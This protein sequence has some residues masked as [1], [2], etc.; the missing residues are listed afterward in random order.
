MLQPNQRAPFCLYYN[1]ILCC[2]Q[3]SERHLFIWKHHIV[4]QRIQPA[5]FCLCDNNILCCSQS[6]GRPEGRC[7]RA[8]PASDR[9]S[10]RSAAGNHQS[11]LWPQRCDDMPKGCPLL[12]QLHSGC[13]GS[14]VRQVQWSTKLLRQGPQSCCWRP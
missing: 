7:V 11:C 6:S 13:Y 1:T 8:R 14:S 10:G 3:S 5:P 12:N 4:L 9:L 2:S